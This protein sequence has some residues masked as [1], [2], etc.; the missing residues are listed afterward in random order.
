MDRTVSVIGEAE[1]SAS[2]DTVVLKLSVSAHEKDYA[3]T[4]ES[5]A[6]QTDKLTGAVKNAGF[7]EKELKTTDFSVETVYKSVRDKN[8]SYE[9]VFDG[10]RCNQSFRLEFPLN[11]SLLGRVLSEI[12]TCGADPEVRISFTVKDTARLK[13]ALL[14]DCAENA[15]KK[16]ELLCRGV[17]AELGKAVSVRCGTEEP[18]FVSGTDFSV[19]DGV[20]P[21]MAR[22]GC[23][24]NMTPQD[25][26]VS[27]SVAFVFEML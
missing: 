23:A 17:G 5:A 2:P 15:R 9:S 12:G 13:E 27:E 14:A 4:S 19:A 8:G 11:M 24:E 6:V 16:A 3:I 25:V 18:T 20:M 10:Y 26:T 22:A 21:L 1:I 7:S